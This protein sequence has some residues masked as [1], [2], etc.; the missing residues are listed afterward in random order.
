M[1]PLANKFE[2]DSLVMPS[3]AMPRGGQAVV[4]IS[5]DQGSARLPGAPVWSLLQV[6]IGQVGAPV[7]DNARI[8]GFLDT[9]RGRRRPRCF[10][11][12][13]TDSPTARRSGWTATLLFASVVNRHTFEEPQALRGRRRSLVEIHG[14]PLAPLRPI[15]R[16]E[17]KDNRAERGAKPRHPRR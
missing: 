15:E 2:P 6:I 11:A 17:Q 8:S 13:P 5:S 9:E 14:Q 3:P 10:D 4:S 1:P 7:I 12:Q 16:L